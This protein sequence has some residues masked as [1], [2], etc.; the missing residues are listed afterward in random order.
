MMDECGV[1]DQTASTL[2]ELWLSAHGWRG[3]ATLGGESAAEGCRAPRVAP[4]ESVDTLTP[5]A[6]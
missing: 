6:L 4:E 3:A 5:L 1:K 2:K